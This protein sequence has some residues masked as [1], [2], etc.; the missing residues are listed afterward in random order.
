MVDGKKGEDVS[1][2][3]PKV[4]N[5]D[6]K[7]WRRLKRSSVLMA[8]SSRIM[9]GAFRHLAKKMIAS[10]KGFSKEYLKETIDRI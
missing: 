1:H 10:G 3:A 4:V 2:R 6:A 9:E 5:L 8:F 7:C